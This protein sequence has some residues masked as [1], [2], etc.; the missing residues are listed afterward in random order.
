MNFTRK[1]ARCLVAASAIALSLAAHADTFSGSASFGDTSSAKNNDYSFSGSFAN[2]NFSFT[3]GMGTVYNDALTITT[4]YV[5]TFNSAPSDQLSV[6]INFTNPNA[7]KAGFNGQGSATF[8]GIF[9]SSSDIDWTTNYQTITFNDGSKVQLYLPNFDFGTG[10]GGWCSDP[11]E[12]LTMSV[13]SNAVTPEPS[14]FLLLGTGLL[15]LIGG[16]AYR[17]SRE[18]EGASAFAMPAL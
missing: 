12:N 5:P 9:G 18:S 2:P 4:N 11:T 1:F 10:I 13:L 16:L 14:S 8:Y 3:G 6:T 17:K 7:A 15:C